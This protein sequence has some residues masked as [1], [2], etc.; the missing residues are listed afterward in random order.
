MKRHKCNFS[1]KKRHNAP[2][3]IY[4]TS[5]TKRPRD[6]WK[7]ISAFLAEMNRSRKPNGMLAVKA[8]NLNEN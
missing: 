1:Y 3:R 4:I 2:S 8:M 7:C 6:V 5:I